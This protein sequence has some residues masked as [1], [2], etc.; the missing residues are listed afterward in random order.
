V[1]FLHERNLLADVWVGP[2]ASTLYP[3]FVW[4]YLSLP[5]FSNDGQHAIRERIVQRWRAFEGLADDPTL[6]PLIFGSGGR[7]DA[8]TLR[9]RAAMLAEVAAEV[10]LASQDVAA[11]AARLL[12]D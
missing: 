3:P 11:L 4:A 6:A 12:R 5:E 10:D 8:D 2:A 1:H 7:Y 9:L